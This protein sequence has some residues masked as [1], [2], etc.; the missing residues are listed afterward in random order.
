MHATNVYAPGLF[1]TCFGEQLFYFMEPLVHLPDGKFGAHVH[2]MIDLCFEAIA[3]SA[4]LLRHQNDG[5]LCLHDM[6]G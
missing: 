4:A 2:L 5:R 6:L 3:F 1:T